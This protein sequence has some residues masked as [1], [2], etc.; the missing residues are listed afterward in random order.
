MTT[1]THVKCDSVIF[2]SVIGIAIQVYMFTWN[3]NVPGLF[4]K[5]VIRFE[6]YID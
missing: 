5:L 1:I 3:T 2:T 4:A 6:T